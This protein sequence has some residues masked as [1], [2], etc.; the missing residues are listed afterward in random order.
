MAN[1][2]PYYTNKQVDKELGGSKVHKWT[3]LEM[4]PKV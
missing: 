1:K 3:W 4:R 2:N